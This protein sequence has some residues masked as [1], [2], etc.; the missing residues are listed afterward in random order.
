[1]RCRAGFNPDQA[2]LQTRKKWEHLGPPEALAHN[3]LAIRI[4]SVNLKHVFGEIKPNR[5]KLHNQR[6]LSMWRSL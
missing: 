6:S 1:M 4:D 2:R 3:R 5:A